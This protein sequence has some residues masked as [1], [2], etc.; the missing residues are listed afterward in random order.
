[1]AEIL[2]VKRSVELPPPP[3]ST[4]IDNYTAL[5]RQYLRAREFCGFSLDEIINSRHAQRYLRDIWL[6]GCMVRKPEKASK[7]PPGNP[8]R[9]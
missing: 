5:Q 4:L 9:S 6:L 3:S 1:M 8:F 2:P 7:L